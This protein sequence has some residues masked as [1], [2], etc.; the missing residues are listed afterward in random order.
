[1]RKIVCSLLLAVAVAVVPTLASS[2]AT[3]VDQWGNPVAQPR[4]SGRAPEPA[5][6]FSV[7]INDEIGNRVA[8]TQMAALPPLGYHFIDSRGASW[9]ITDGFIEGAARGEGTIQAVKVTLQARSSTKV[10]A[11]RRSNRISND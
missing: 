9:V 11:V 10:P 4:Y 2:Q 1:M 6:L 8:S 3:V 7:T 5:R